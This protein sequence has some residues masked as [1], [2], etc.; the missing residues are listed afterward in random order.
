MKSS[1]TQASHTGMIIKYARFS[2][3]AAADGTGY[4]VSFVTGQ[5]MTFK[6]QIINR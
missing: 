5:V 1:M 2:R 6:K 4:P 3:S